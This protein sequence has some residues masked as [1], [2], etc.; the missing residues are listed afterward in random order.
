[1]IFITV[2]RSYFI[3]E[4]F[5]TPP[6]RANNAAFRHLSALSSHTKAKMKRAD[7]KGFTSKEIIPSRVLLLTTFL[8]LYMW[9]YTEETLH[10]CRISTATRL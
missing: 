1:M 5:V 4:N 3:V 7:S 2:T 6:T 10:G 9:G 8:V